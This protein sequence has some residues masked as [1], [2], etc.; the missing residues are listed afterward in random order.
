VKAVVGEYPQATAVER[1]QAAV[2]QYITTPLHTTVNLDAFGRRV[3]CLANGQRSRAEIFADLLQ[4]VR[5]G[6]FS[7]AKPPAEVR[8]LPVEKQ[9]EHS[10]NGVLNDLGRLGAFCG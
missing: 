7:L 10:L 1:Y 8:D 9:L 5:D 3:I 4:W 2:Q 6:H